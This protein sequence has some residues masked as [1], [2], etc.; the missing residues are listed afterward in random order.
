MILIMPIESASSGC[1]SV[2]RSVVA[3]LPPTAPGLLPKSSTVDSG[4]IYHMNIC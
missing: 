2:D 3:A 4:S 1:A